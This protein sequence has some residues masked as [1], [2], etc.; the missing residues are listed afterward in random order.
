MLL[1]LDR[2]KSVRRSIGSI[3]INGRTGLDLNLQDIQHFI[4]ILLQRDFFTLLRGSRL[5]R[6]IH[7]STKWYAHCNSVAVDLVPLVPIV[8]LVEERHMNC[9]RCITRRGFFGAPFKSL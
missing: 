3:V 1:D 9:P 6:C 7:R 5:N 4:Q 8:A 2:E